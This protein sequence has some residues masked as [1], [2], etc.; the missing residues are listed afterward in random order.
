MENLCIKNEGFIY[1]EGYNK[2]ISEYEVADEKLG[3]FMLEF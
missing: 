3:N 2:I 1:I